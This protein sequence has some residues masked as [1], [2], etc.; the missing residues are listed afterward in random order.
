MEWH[1]R[2]PDRLGYSERDFKVC[3]FCGALNPVAN[4]EC[5]I[6]TWS[7]RFHD[8]RETVRE[9]MESLRGKYGELDESLFEE[10]V[11]PSTPPRKSLWAELLTSIKRLFSRA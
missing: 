4:L 8:D 11:V 6:C 10:E 5:M 3:D 9:A 7:G 2:G 1:E